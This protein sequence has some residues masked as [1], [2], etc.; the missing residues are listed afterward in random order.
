M[1]DLCFGKLNACLFST[2]F[3]FRLA[4]TAFWHY[5]LGL[6]EAFFLLTVTLK[7]HTLPVFLLVSTCHPLSHSQSL[8]LFSPSHTISPALSVPAVVNQWEE[9]ARHSPSSEGHTERSLPAGPVD[10]LALIIHSWYWRQI[11]SLQCRELVR[12]SRCGCIDGEGGHQI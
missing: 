2:G 4:I 5:R 3:V 8:S 6:E 11:R 1:F 7:R 9:Q 10:S 12:G